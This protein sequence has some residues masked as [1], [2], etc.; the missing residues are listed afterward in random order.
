MYLFYNVLIIS[1]FMAAY[2]YM[3]LL[4]ISFPEKHEPVMGKLLSRKDR[5]ITYL[6]YD[7]QNEL[8]NVLFNSVRDGIITC[9]KKGQFFFIIMSTTQDIIKKVS[10]TR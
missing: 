4:V 6:T 3:T 9:R 2:L 7:M 1:M 5:T 10:L 8:I